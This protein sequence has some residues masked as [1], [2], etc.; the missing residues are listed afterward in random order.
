MRPT[1]ENLDLV[2]QET[3]DS[4]GPTH[5]RPTECGGRQAIQTRPDHS[6]QMVP[7]STGFSDNMQQVAPA[8]DRPFCYEVQ[9]QVASV[10][11]TS[12]GSPGHCSRFTQSAMGGSGCICLPTSSHLKQSGGEVAKLPL[13]KIDSYCPG[14]AQHALVLGPS[15]NV[16][17][18]PIDPAH[19]PNLLTQ[20]FNQ[21]PHRNLTNLNLHAWLLKP[22][23]SRN[24]ASLSQ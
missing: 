1:L 5:P 19:L 9:Q 14:M 12:A 21:I 10:Y 22:Q 24:R 13:Q 3:S 18:D 11:V 17:P 15:G 8:T 4:K 23:Q 16:Q 6:D 20:P 2:L 7:P